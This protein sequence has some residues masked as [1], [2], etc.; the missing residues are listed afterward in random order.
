M[1][2]IWLRPIDYFRDQSGDLIEYKV[3]N[4]KDEIGKIFSVAVDK[5]GNIVCGLK[6]TKWKGQTAIKSYIVHS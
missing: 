4:W 1:E 6:L 2:T 3:Q 5:N